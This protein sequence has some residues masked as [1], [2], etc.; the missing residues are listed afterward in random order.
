M[1]RTQSSVGMN[2]CMYIYVMYPVPLQRLLY[3]ALHGA[4]LVLIHFQIQSCDPIRCYGKPV[5]RTS[6]IK[7][8]LISSQGWVRKW[9]PRLFLINCR[10]DHNVVLCFWWNARCFKVRQLAPQYGATD[11][12]IKVPSGENTELKRSPFKAWSRSV[13]SHTSYAYCKGFLPCLF[14]PFRSLHLHFFQTS[15]VFFLCWLWLTPVLMYDPQNKI[16][17][18]AGCRFPCRAPA[19]YK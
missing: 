17:H 15:P 4:L 2:T 6:E 19:E 5:E 18:P 9:K 3:R 11:A 14:L 12:E 16:G 13:Y 10:S 1:L 8:Y 7:T